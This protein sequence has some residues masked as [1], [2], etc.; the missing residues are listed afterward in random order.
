[1][2]TK[3]DIKQEIKSN[4]RLSVPFI[5]S[6]TIYSLSGFV[7]TA[8]VA[9]L[10]QV[11]LAASVL[12]S[13][14]WFTLS[15]LFFGILNAVSV[16]VSHQYGAK[17]GEGIN[18]FMGQAYVIGFLMSI[19]MILLLLCLPYLL[20]YS[21]Q[22]ANVLHQARLYTYALMWTVPSLIYL[23]ITEQFLG[24]I[25]KAKVVLVTSVIIVPLEITAIYILMFGK[26]GLPPLGIS[27]LGFGFALSYF[28]TAVGLTLYLCLTKAYKNYHIYRHIN[29]FHLASLNMLIK[30]GLPLGLA[31][32][33]EVSGFAIL[34]LWMGHFGTTMLAAHQIVM[35]FLGLMVTLLFAMSQA[36]TVRLGHLAGAND[37]R[38]LP[39]AVVIGLGL[40]FA[41]I[42]LVVLGFNIYHLPLLSLDINIH[43]IH[44][45]QLITDTLSIFTIVAFWLI[46]ENFRIIGQGG[47]RGLKDTISLF[48]IAAISFWGVGLPMAYLLG[49]HTTMGGHG[50]WWGF[51]VGIVVGAIITLWR[52]YYLLRSDRQSFLKTRLEAKRT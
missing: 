38:K 4:L 41:V 45:A 51:S 49:F 43:D 37:Y 35:Q 7:G 44:N 19:I 23:I 2:L 24:G 42:V 18:R 34:T 30:I 13:M 26:L 28:T 22:P 25:G 48:I 9:R 52:L 5:A 50:L 31:Q 6:Q 14:L 16:A 32:G 21:H 1:M 12:V 29:Q 33:I 20:S 39:G 27:A 40:S 36:V 15:I 10:G 17:D 47:L 3:T 11:S 8:M 46:I